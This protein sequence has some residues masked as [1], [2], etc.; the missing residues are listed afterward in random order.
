MDNA[1][2]DLTTDAFQFYYENSIKVLDWPQYSPDLNPFEN[3]WAIMNRKFRGR[4]FV[5]IN[6][7]N[8]NCIKYGLILRIIHSKHYE[9]ASLIELNAD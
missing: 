9:E 6:S 5:T 4:K 1:K 3:L 8:M 2:Y 7:L